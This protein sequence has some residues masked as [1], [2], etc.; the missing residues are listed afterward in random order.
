[1]TAYARYIKRFFDVLIA[2]LFFIPSFLVLL[3]CA[4]FIYVE[5][6]KPVFFKQVRTGLQGKTFQIYKLRTMRLETERSGHE[7]SDMERITKSGKIIRS[8]SFDELPQLWNVLKGD[9]SFIG[10]RPLLPEYLPLYTKEQMRRH[11]VRPGLSGWAQVHGRN[12]VPWKKRFEMDVWYVDHLSFLLDVKVFFL[13][14]L[15]LIKRQGVNAEE[16]T[17]MLPFTGEI[18]E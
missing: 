9:M 6:R 11:D 12:E 13:T 10:P 2:L 17:T 14:L 1:M 7:L 3:C 8:L 16:G 5:D 15:N 4:F 18:D